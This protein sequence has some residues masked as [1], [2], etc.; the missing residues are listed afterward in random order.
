[1]STTYGLL[2][3]LQLRQFND[4]GLLLSGGR[5]HFFRAGTTTPLETYQ[6]ALGV[7]LNTNP[8]VLDGAGSA[9]IFLLPAQ[10]RVE[11]YSFD[12]ELIHEIDNVGSGGGASIGGTGSLAI[13]KNYQEVR[14]LDV[15]YDS[16]LVLGR[17]DVGD[18]AGGIFIKSLSTDSDDDGILLVR[19]TSTRYMRQLNGYVDPVFYG[20]QYSN[21]LDQTVYL[22]KALDA[23][24]DYQLPVIISG[25]CNIASN[26]T[27]P[28]GARIQIDGALYGPA[29]NPPT[30]TF[31]DYAVLV[32]CS[33]AGIRLP[34]KL[35]IGCVQG[36]ISSSWL[37]GG[38]DTEL[39]RLSSISDNGYSVNIDKEYSL[40][41][42]INFPKN[43][44]IN[45]VGG[46]FI[47]D[48]GMINIVIADLQYNGYDQIFEYTQSQYLNVLDVGRAFR[49]EWSGAIADGLNNDS[50]ALEVAFHTGWAK[51]SG[52]G[53]YRLCKMV[54]PA[55]VLIEGT[56]PSALSVSVP[57]NTATLPT[58]RLMLSETGSLSTLVPD[59][60]T[61]PNMI[62]PFVIADLE[63]QQIT[64]IQYFNG[65]Y[66][67]ATSPG[68]L[69]RLSAISGGWESTKL[70]NTPLRFFGL[71]VWNGNLYA[72]VR[73]ATATN[74]IYL[75]TITGNTATTTL[76]ID[77]G[78][79][80]AK[81]FAQIGS[82]IYACDAG[83]DVRVLSGSTFGSSIGAFLGGSANVV[84]G[85][86]EMGP[87]L[88][89]LCKNFTTGAWT[90]QAMSLLNVPA[91][92]TVLT[93]LIGYKP[94]GME[95]YGNDFYITQS[96]GNI[97]KV[98]N[99]G[100]ISLFT[101]NASDNIWLNI[102]YVRGELL[103]CGTSIPEIDIFS[104]SG[105]IDI[106]AH[107]S[108]SALGN[109]VFKDVV[110]D[111][112]VSNQGGGS[113]SANG[114][115]ISFINSIPYY[116]L[117]GAV[118]DAQDTILDVLIQFAPT[119]N[120]SNCIF[121]PFGLPGT[122]SR[123]HYQDNIVL[124][125]T[126]LEADK[127]AMVLGTDADGKII[128]KDVLTLEDLTVTDNIIAKNISISNKLEFPI[129]TNS[130]ST[131]NI[132]HTDPAVTVCS[133]SGGAIVANL[134]A[135]PLP[136][137][138]PNI[139]F[140]VRT[141]DSTAYMTIGINQVHLG[142]RVTP[143]LPPIMLGSFSGNKTLMI[144][145]FIDGKWAIC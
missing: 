98:T 21:A 116:V 58:P 32:S 106:T 101:T 62:H 6:D 118:V 129:S 63:D 47:V 72:S 14:D 126:Y 20:L 31:Q 27:V 120:A 82:T 78:T 131:V 54:R 49:P 56:M 80:T 34:I 68:Y 110:I 136:A 8:V 105:D 46:R 77:G 11:I 141:G 90:V 91:D 75:V 28:T 94:V 138:A 89:A 15:E 16:V 109:I 48:I 97:I 33:N 12:G 43:L 1:M 140:I 135:G 3:F 53:L 83:G 73:N 50:D 18:G 134:P 65:Q 122:D 139:R 93:T 29:I 38:T 39:A 145:M 55:S 2:P 127:N 59:A 81:Y 42:S 44:A 84:Y 9:K 108:L 92:V 19:G 4:S 143:N 114:G 64:S 25:E 52:D 51:L 74:E 125:T 95:S 35:G 36:P 87:L 10:Y 79:Y 113:L 40:G 117:T 102:H 144:C 128:P 124:R 66:I 107:I 104:E 130:G 41:V 100:I 142:S 37:G 103:L 111:G 70:S 45:F 71:Y 86:C 13:C 119:I 115:I 24:I 133:Y 121:L 76:F 123:R 69:Y 96:T 67:V 99:S 57:F 85:F 5:I 137:G 22:V 60:P 23:S 88:Y 30:I 26:V 61:E 17:T 112:S 132:S 7:T